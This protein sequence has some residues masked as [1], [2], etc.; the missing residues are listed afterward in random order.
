[1]SVVGGATFVGALTSVV[2]PSIG[3]P[4]GVDH[5]LFDMTIDP[6]GGFPGGFAV[7]G[8]TIFGAS[9]PG[10]GQQFG[11]PVQ[12][13]DFEHIGG[14]AAGSTHTVRIDLDSATHP[15]TFAPGQSFNEIFG[16]VGSGPDDII[17]T[18]FQIFLNKSNDSPVTVYIDNVR[19]VVP[20]PATFGLLGM[21]AVVM[22]AFGL[23]RRVG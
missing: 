4:P 11:L 1:M 23:R 8:V 14:K 10:P 12:F 15:T 22:G 2:H 5:I 6:A 21:G 13:A 3:D 9:Q 16:T 20:E 18:G 7:V 17:P 19:V